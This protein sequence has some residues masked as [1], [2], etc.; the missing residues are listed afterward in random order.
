MYHIKKDMTVAGISELR[1]HSAE[2]LKRTKQQNVILQKHSEP[3]AVLMNY[4]RYL[5]YEQM[6]DFAE[7]YINDCIAKDRDSKTTEK[8]FIDIDEW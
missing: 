6:L 4:E 1:Q 7:D 2:I 5:K 3:V 8:D